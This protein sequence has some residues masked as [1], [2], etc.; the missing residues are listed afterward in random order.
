ML[1]GNRR[2]GLD[3]VNH[4][5]ALLLSLLTDE[6]AARQVAS[7]APNP[8]QLLGTIADVFAHLAS[9]ARTILRGRVGHGPS[10]PNLAKGLKQKKQTMDSFLVLLS[11]LAPA[12]A[13]ISID[14]IPDVFNTLDE[15][16][17]YWAA[18][19]RHHTALT[20]IMT[21]VMNDADTISTNNEESINRFYAELLGNKRL[22]D[23]CDT[24]RKATHKLDTAFRPLFNK[25]LMGDPSSPDY[26]RAVHLRLQFLGM[27]VFEDPPQYLQVA[28]LEARTPLFREYLT[29]ASLALR[30]LFQQR[31]N[32]IKAAAVNP[33]HQLSLQCGIAWNLFIM[34]LFC[35]DPPTR[36]EALHLL[37][38]YPG[39][40]GLWDT[41]AL[42]ALALKNRDVER[43]NMAEGTPDEQWRR[44][45]R[46]E[47]VFED[48][49]ERV[50][51]R[52][53][54]KDEEKGGEWTLV[55]EAAEVRTR[56]ED[57][58]WVRQPLRGQS[59]LLMADLYADKF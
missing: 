18:T 39:H 1:R 9:Q 54:A 43:A 23:F 48:A 52:F 51:L 36:D 19:R 37:R 6:D 26:I 34:A 40:D 56:V 15:F 50:V 33:A 25:V 58:R 8:K 59:W 16:G 20:K 17:Q 42:H 10:L 11:D 35:R 38:D 49:G 41:R 3:H 7:V 44:L 31:N 27:V 21:D 47:F 32:D 28:A 29:L 2:A 55:E 45:W 4:G 30:M 5:L 12:P 14:T 57:V 22:R 46:R 13:T 53:M 24:S